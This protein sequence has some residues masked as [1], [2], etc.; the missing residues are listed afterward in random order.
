MTRPDMTPEEFRDYLSDLSRS[1]YESFLDSDEHQQYL[2]Q[3]TPFSSIMEEEQQFRK[4]MNGF[5]VPEP[6]TNI[7]A[8]VMAKIAEQK[9]NSEKESESFG[10]KVVEIF[11]WKFQVPAW[12]VAA[13]LL[14][15]AG[16]IGLNLI[17]G[18]HK[19]DGVGPAKVADSEPA[20]TAVPDPPQ[21]IHVV[22]GT[23]D[24][25]VSVTG[26]SG[27]PFGASPSPSLVII[28]GAPS[29]SWV[30]DPDHYQPNDYITGNNEI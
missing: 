6:A 16:S 27:L 26:N 7:A 24:P 8:S 13:I 10:A 21:I 1:E 3:G 15:L 2:E 25:V 9:M 11:S 30:L 19:G 17:N 28:M 20:D 18:T 29:A 14:V 5:G 22:P 4:S 23:P 12:G